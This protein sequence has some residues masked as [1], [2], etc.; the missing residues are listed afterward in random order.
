M[1]TTPYISVFGGS[2]P[3]PTEYLLYLGFQLP[4]L[5]TGHEEG[6]DGSACHILLESEREGVITSQNNSKC[7]IWV[8]E[9]A[10]YSKYTRA[11][12][13]LKK[14]EDEAC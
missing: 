13:D 7:S 11:E 9:W 1:M 10:Q 5:N 4:N 3:K 14:S 2:D 6:N 12:T 8:P